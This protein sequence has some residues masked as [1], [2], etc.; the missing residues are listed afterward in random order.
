LIKSNAASYGAEIYKKRER[1][2]MSDIYNEELHKKFFAIVGSPDE[3]KKISQ[4]EAARRMDYTAGVVS[5]YKSKTYTGN[6]KLIEEKV[7]EFLQREERRHSIVAVPTAETSATTQ[8]CKA[9]TMA[10][11]EVDIA[12]IVGEAG[13]GKTTAVRQYVKKTH[14][15][16]LVEVDPGFTQRALIHAIARQVGVDPIGG[17]NVIIERVINALRTRDAVLIVDEADYLT[18]A[19]LELVRRVIH[20]KSNTGVV[21]V[22]LPRLEYKIRSL[23]NDHQQLASR[24][25]IFL[26]VAKMSKSDGEKILSGVWKDLAKDVV[27]AFVKTAN[28]SARTLV[29]LMGR[30]HQ[31]MALNKTEKPDSDIIARAGELLMR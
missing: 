12:V 13:T 14:S 28:G 21:L 22:G 30:V 6:I 5:A 27:E 10:Q 1:D 19:S 20:D 26:K 11:D 24:V 15:A 18:D 25:G 31:I 17:T 2:C 9:I 3:K 16:L 7:A 23:K 29:K 8:V 4:A